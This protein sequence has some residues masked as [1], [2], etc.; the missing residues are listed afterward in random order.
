[1]VSVAPIC[2]CEE[3]LTGQTGR[4]GHGSY[5]GSQRIPTTM[6]HKD[7]MAAGWKFEKGQSGSPDL[8]EM[9]YYCPGVDLEN[10]SNRIRNVS[11]FRN[12]SDVSKILER[13][14]LELPNQ[15]WKDLSEEK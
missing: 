4:P 3:F 12:A 1:M 2:L 5:Q 13:I 11:E 15:C 7:L 8:Q 10:Q 14:R 9:M 6:L